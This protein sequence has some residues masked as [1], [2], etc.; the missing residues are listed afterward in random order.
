[1]GQEKHKQACPDIMIA[2]N[3]NNEDDISMY[4]CICI[5]IVDKIYVL[6]IFLLLN[7]KNWPSVMGH[8]MLALFEI[9]LYLL[10]YKYFNWQIYG[11]HS[12]KLNQ[13][14]FIQS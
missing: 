1:M 12:E 11:F 2:S 6:E 7:R 5:Y 8:F 4:I 3:D 9:W 13:I 10:S 14:M